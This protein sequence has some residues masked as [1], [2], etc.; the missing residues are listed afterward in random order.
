MNRKFLLTSMLLISGVGCRPGNPVVDARSMEEKSTPAPAI[1]EIPLRFASWEETEKLIASHRGKVVVLDVW[2]TWCA[3]C[4]KEFPNL[5]KLQQQDA[6]QVTCL[7]LNCN[8]AGIVDEPPQKAQAD[9]RSF[10]R[11]QRAT[12]ENIICTD[13]DEQLFAKLNAASIPI[14]RVYDKQGKLSKQFVNDDGE[15]G[16]K[17]FTYADHILPLVQSLSK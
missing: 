16:E 10:L 13:P 9:I 12:F 5:V 7:S 17:G 14:V 4:L 8:Y 6:D 2:S 15:Y 11:K 3:P 1:S